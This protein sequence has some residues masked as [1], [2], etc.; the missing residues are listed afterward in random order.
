[1]AAFRE[2]GERVEDREGFRSSRVG[3]QKIK[4]RNNL[5][6]RDPMTM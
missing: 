2:R 5:V 4:F 1:M 3:P 6:D